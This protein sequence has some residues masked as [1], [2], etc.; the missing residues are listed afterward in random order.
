MVK[1]MD[2]ADKNTLLIVDD[3]KSNLKLLTQILGAEYTI[4]TATN[5]ENAI[6]KAKEYMPDLILLDIIM[7]GINGYETLSELRKCDKTQNTPVI[8]ITGL[9]SSE[10]EE[11]GLSLDAADY[12]SKPFSAM[13]VKLR[14]R[15]Q[16]QMV[17][18]LRTIEHLSKI[19]QL[20]D[21]PNRRSFDERLL[22]EWNHAQREQIPVSIL[23]LD[24]DKFKNY[25]DT[26]GH[27]QGDIALQTVAKII[28]VIPKRSIDFAA[29]WGGEEFV[30]LLPN[31]QSAAAVDIAEKIRAAVEKEELPGA[32]NL[33]TKITVSIGV[34]TQVPAHTDSI[35]SFISG[36]DKALYTAKETGRNRVI[37]SE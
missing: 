16:I 10:D 18:Q 21:I 3:E 15:N 35:N 4:Y 25:N 36:A 2:G 14:V 22:I 28:S 5:G 23:I 37:A 12:I 27:Q 9:S 20:T 34:N 26:Y 17:N 32:G 24:V 33:I 29:R 1:L 31:T 8:F 13:I 30:V 6:E 11:K 19:D 7:P